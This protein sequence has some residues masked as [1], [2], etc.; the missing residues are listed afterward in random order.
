[1]SKKDKKQQRKLQAS[2]LKELAKHQVDD[3]SPEFLAQLTT[4]RSVTVDKALGLAA[5]WACIRFLSE[6]IS[7]L[8]L[9]IYRKNADGTRQVA[10]DHPLYKVLC[11]DPNKLQTPMKLVQFLVTCSQISSAAFFEKKT[12]NGRLIALN[13]IQPC[14]VR[15]IEQDKLTGRLKY[16]LYRNNQYEEL[17]EAAVWMVSG[18]NGLNTLLGCNPI[19]YGRNLM[20]NAISSNES[21]ANFYEKGLSASGFVTSERFLK[22]EQ[23]TNLNQNLGLYSGSANAGKVML[24]DGGLKF[25]GISIDPEA[26]QLLETRNHDA[27]EICRFF[28]VPPALVGYT[29]KQSSWASS[30]EVTATHVLTFT[31][32]PILVNIE[33]SISKY[34]IAPNER[35]SVYAEFAVEGFLRADSEARANFYNQMLNNGAMSRNEVRA[36]ENLAPVDGGDIHTVQSALIPLDKVGKNYETVGTKQ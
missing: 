10:N 4:M 16:K 8:P 12:I 6:T 22:G 35:D 36:K 29:D 11:L 23:R 28:R 2:V 15:N 1:M 3:T 25:Q 19:D 34:L 26:A 20:K 30:L 7:T 17:D 18:F 5:V 24:L 21:A 31:L 9:K 33:Q 14:E 32:L 13:P 27:L